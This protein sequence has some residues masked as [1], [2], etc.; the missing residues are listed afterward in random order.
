MFV[1]NPV[2]TRTKA[3]PPPRVRENGFNSVW[4]L[5]VMVPVILFSAV[6]KLDGMLIYDETYG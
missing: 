5:N 3:R 6:F 1:G 4:A 2:K